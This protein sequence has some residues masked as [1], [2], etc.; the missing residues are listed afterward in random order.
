M[1]FTQTQQILCTQTHDI[2]DIGKATS[3]LLEDTLP[4]G[5][6]EY[7]ITVRLCNDH[8]QEE[9][10]VHNVTTDRQFAMKLFWQICRGE[11]TPCALCEVLAELI[12]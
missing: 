6:R 5:M 3:M 9:R 2:P 7:S 8:G 4:N 12:P 10:T 1:N 11:V